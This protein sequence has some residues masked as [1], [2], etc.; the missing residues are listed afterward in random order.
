MGAGEGRGIGKSEPKEPLFRVYRGPTIG[1][2][3]SSSGSLTRRR[4]DTDPT[5]ADVVGPARLERTPP[6]TLRSASDSR[7]AD[8]GEPC[9]SPLV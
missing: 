1:S 3:D 8:L 5:W 4:T 6:P 7:V 9:L 2:S